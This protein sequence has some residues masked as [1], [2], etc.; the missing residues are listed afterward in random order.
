MMEGNFFQPFETVFTKPGKK[1]PAILDT[2]NSIIKGLET[3]PSLYDHLNECY[4]RLFV[5]RKEGIIA[6]L[7]H[8]CYE[9]ENAPMMGKSAIRMKNLFLS[10]GLSMADRVHEPPDH[11]AIE[12]EY[13]FF[14]LQESCDDQGDNLEKFVSDEAGSF[15]TE[16]LLPW[17]KIFH[18]RLQSMDED[19]RFYVLAS[20][21]L[22]QLLGLISKNDQGCPLKFYFPFLILKL[23]SLLYLHA[24]SSLHPLPGGIGLELNPLIWK[25]ILKYHIISLHTSVFQLSV[26]STAVLPGAMFLLG[27]HQTTSIMGLP[28]C[29]LYHQ[30]TIFDLILPRLMA[31]ERP[32]QRDLAK[33]C[34]GGLCQN[35]KPCRFPSCPFGKS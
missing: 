29:G 25:N 4:V 17:V 18:Q 5:N 22:V 28:A 12:L 27:Y 10:K 34:H 26:F 14:L 3:H 15:C 16:T 11:L 30:T 19:C 13:L 1:S 7:Y 23:P 35:C 6:H 21:L 8:S 24:A 31:G 9:F 33:L 20:G 2:I 32:G